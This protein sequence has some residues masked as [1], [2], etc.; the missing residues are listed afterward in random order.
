MKLELGG[1]AD[2]LGG[3][4]TERIIDHASR[5][6]GDQVV[7]VNAPDHDVTVADVMVPAAE[8][9]AARLL[10]A[11]RSGRLHLTPRMRTSATKQSPR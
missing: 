7:A 8:G 11:E 1:H 9:A 3:Q 4:W 6:A 10:A 5:L 2:G